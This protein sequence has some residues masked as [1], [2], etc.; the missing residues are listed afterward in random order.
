MI[1]VLQRLRQSD[2][3]KA[4]HN[5]FFTD[6]HGKK[7]KNDMIAQYLGKGVFHLKDLNHDKLEL[8]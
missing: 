4:D 3:K 7:K 6:L 2:E 1:S 5:S 8:P